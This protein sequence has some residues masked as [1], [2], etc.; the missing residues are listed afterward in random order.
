MNVERPE[1]LW[2][3]VRMVGGGMM[4]YFLDRGWARTTEIF[5]G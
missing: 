2:P 5:R 1:G 3:V 4:G